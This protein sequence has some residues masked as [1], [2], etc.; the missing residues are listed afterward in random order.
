MGQRNAQPVADPAVGLYVDGVYL[1]RVV[2]AVLNVVDAE[3]VEVLRGPQGTLYGKNTLGGAVNIVSTIPT[4]DFGGYIDLGVG[5]YSECNAKGSVQFPI[6]ADKLAARASISSMQHDGYDANVITGDDMGSLDSTAGRA[7]LRWTPNDDVTALLIADYTSERNSGQG[8]HPTVI[9]PTTTNGIG[10]YNTLVSG[11]IRGGAGAFDSR[12]VTNN[13]DSLAT[14]DFLEGN[15]NDLDAWGVAANIEWDI[16]SDVTLTSISGYRWLKTHVASD[17]DGSPVIYN[18]NEVFDEQNQWSQELRL[19][20]TALDGRLQWQFGGYYALE[21]ISDLSLI[22]KAPAVPPPIGFRVR[23][24]IDATNTSWAFFTQETFKIRDGLSVT[25]GIRYSSDEKD[26]VAQGLF[27]GFVNYPPTQLVG[28]WHS[29]TPRVSL[30]YNPNE[31]FLAYV[32]Y[33][34]G[35]KSG[36]LNYVILSRNDLTLFDPETTATWELGTKLQFFDQRL[37]V[38]TAIFHTLY[39]DLQFEHFFFSADV[40]GTGTFFCS[41]TLNAAQAEIDGVEVEIAAMPFKGFELFAN[42]TYMDNEVTEVDPELVALQ[43]FDPTVLNLDTT[44]ARTPEWTATGGASYSFSLGQLGGLTLRADYSYRSL[45]Y[46][47]TANVS[48]ASQDAYGLF[49][50]GISFDTNDG[51]WRIAVSG[52]NL[53]DKLFATSGTGTT[54]PSDGYA[55]VS[56]GAPRTLTASFR[57]RFGVF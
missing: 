13:R 3:R 37:Q 51:R 45:V 53:T 29:T 30:E 1:G 14:A 9:T 41:R 11:S 44:L 36:G 32:S 34:E 22:T 8:L 56:Y 2:G 43:A 23:Q 57:Y 19:A 12:Y 42:A 47:D 50:A 39:E 5:D 4:G 52:Q 21:D 46:F 17:V 55:F 31:D 6:V 26:N 35:F 16:A 40:C 48:G 38:N 15:I 25:A 18:A 27:N 54:L 24:Q 33:A 49:N 20:G 7:M 10:R 28:R